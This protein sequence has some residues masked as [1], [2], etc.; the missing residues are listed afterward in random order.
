MWRV[1]LALEELQVW[2]SGSGKVRL[3]SFREFEKRYRIGNKNW[4]F[5]YCILWCTYY[6]RS[7][8]RDIL[9]GNT[10]KKVSFDF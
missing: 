4:R 10:Y 1:R 5:F 2:H 7:D 9:S 8:S 6:S 3:V